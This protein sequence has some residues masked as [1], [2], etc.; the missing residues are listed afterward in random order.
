[1]G[2]GAARTPARTSLRSFGLPAVFPSLPIWLSD[3]PGGT[4]GDWL[5]SSVDFRND[6]REWCQVRERRSNRPVS[7]VSRVSAVT[8]PARHVPSPVPPQRS[9]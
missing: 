3:M 9:K 4:G 1:M 8:A 7:G 2:I 5:P 6:E